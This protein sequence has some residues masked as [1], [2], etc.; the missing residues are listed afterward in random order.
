LGE[1]HESLLVS[2]HHTQAQVLRPLELC[3]HFW[4]T[5]VAFE[6]RNSKSI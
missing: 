1:G 4:V 3:M 5:L 2:V 6:K